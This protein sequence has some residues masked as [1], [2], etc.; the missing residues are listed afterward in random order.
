MGSSFL[1]KVDIGV[2]VGGNPVE[3]ADVLRCYTKRI[4]KA[5]FDVWPSGRK[6]G[7]AESRLANAVAASLG[8]LE[9]GLERD[10][11]DYAAWFSSMAQTAAMAFGCAAGY[12]ICEPLQTVGSL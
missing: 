6:F 9:I 5:Y 4:A 2:H 10:E 8:R 3:A 7:E 12:N 11:V 1:E